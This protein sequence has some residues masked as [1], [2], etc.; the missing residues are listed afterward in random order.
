[1][2]ST[3]ELVNLQQIGKLEFGEII[4]STSISHNKLRFILID[5]SF[6]EIFHSFQIPER[7]AFHWERRHIDS[8]I[9]RHDNIPHSAWKKVSSFPWHFH[10]HTENHVKK[11]NFQ[12]NPA[13]NLRSFLRFVKNILQPRIP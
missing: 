13:E 6:L 11:S 10:D 4:V 8:T 12:D 9:Y 3:P 1:M 7:W 5:K 2:N